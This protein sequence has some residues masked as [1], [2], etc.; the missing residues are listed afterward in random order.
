MPYTIQQAVLADLELLAPLFDGYRQ[1]YGAAPDPKAAR[2][3]LFERFEHHESVIF[4]ATDPRDRSIG[5][6]F[7]QL[8]PI[9]SSVSM[10][11]FFLLNDLFVAPQARG[12]GVGLGL[13]Q[14]AEAFARASKAKGLML[15]TDIDNTG[16]Q[17]LYIR[18]GWRLDRQFINFERDLE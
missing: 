17:A 8:Y 14:A 9:F 11:R 7:T 1:F 3:F 5:L 16:A 2:H 6:G 10:Q 12:G 13:L 4:L 15:Q 18:A